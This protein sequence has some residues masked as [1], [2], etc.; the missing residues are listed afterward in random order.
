MFSAS[1]SVAR[2]TRNGTNIYFTDSTTNTLVQAYDCSWAPEVT[3]TG[4]TIVIH[5]PVA[6]WIPGHSY[7]VTFDSGI[8]D[9]VSLPFHFLGNLSLFC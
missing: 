4:F 5:F 2:S 1:I 6:P 8:Y 3:Y 9:V 7:Y